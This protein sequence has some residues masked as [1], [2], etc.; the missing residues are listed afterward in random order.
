MPN[1]YLQF[2]PKSAEVNFA[3]V[4]HTFKTKHKRFT[5]SYIFF[6]RL[7]DSLNIIMPKLCLMNQNERSVYYGRYSLP[8][9]NFH[10]HVK[11]FGRK[12]NV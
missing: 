3:N 4:L 6:D 12:Q 1:C 2:V 7:F 9:A 5:I 11:C 10:R 8:H